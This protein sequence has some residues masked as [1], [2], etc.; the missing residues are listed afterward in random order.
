MSSTVTLQLGQCG[1]QLGSALFGKLHDE[2]SSEPSAETG[3]A[4]SLTECYFRTPSSFSS[5]RCGRGAAALCP[6]AVALD[7]EPRVVQSLLETPSP[8]SPAGGGNG[9]TAD[10]RYDPTSCFWK[11]AGAANNWAN[12]Y[13]N[14]VGVRDQLEL[15]LHRETEACDRL[16]GFLALWSVAGGT[17]SGLGAFVLEQIACELYPKVPILGVCVWPF[18]TGEVATQSY[19]AVLSA[20]VALEHADAL[21]LV[22][23][24]KFAE[25]VSNQEAGGGAGAPAGLAGGG[26][27]VA[28]A[29]RFRGG[30]PVGT[31][32]SG[33]MKLVDHSSFAKINSAI[34]DILKANFL[35]HPVVG[36]GTGAGGGGGGS[37]LLGGGSSLFS[38]SRSR[39]YRSCFSPVVQQLGSHPSYKLLTARSVP[40]LS[41]A[42]SL[43]NS[44]TWAG[45]AKRLAHSVR[46]HTLLDTTA[47]RNYYSPV[48]QVVS[49]VVA[50]RGPGLT[51]ADVVKRDFAPFDELPY[52]SESLDPLR[53]IIDPRPVGAAGA[54]E[55]SLSMLANDATPVR[56]LD[57][58]VK[59]AAGMVRSSC[60]VHQYEAFGVGR[61]ELGEAILNVERVRGEYERLMISR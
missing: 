32:T 50:A 24:E 44:D 46:H 39:S 21:V 31:G 5:P 49:A 41:A 11:Q 59:K 15:A 26:G 60:Y 36:G 35:P 57:K 53:V 34:A 33:R 18:D 47:T 29:R 19:N 58:A 9:T 52:W 2:L 25:I 43:F 6:R 10:W 51:S 42:S 12:G 61:E 48:H 22:E 1:N 3:F 37:S 55:K 23:N 28:G 27:L 13:A 16:D 4:Q 45:L 30:A 56:V 54:A 38:S 17:G 40:Q 20:N 14:G 8:T 7:M